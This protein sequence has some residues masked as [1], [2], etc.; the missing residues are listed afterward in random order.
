MSIS[1]LTIYTTAAAT[2]PDVECT[3]TVFP[4][5]YPR[6]A[7]MMEPGDNVYLGRYLVSG[8][9]SA[10]LYLEVRADWA[11]RTGCACG[12][13]ASARAPAWRENPATIRLSAHPSSHSTPLTKPTMNTK[14]QQQ[15]T[16]INIQPQQRQNETTGPGGRRRHRRR[17]PREER[18][19]A[20]RPADALPRR[21]LERRAAQHA[22]RPAAAVGLRQGVPRGAGAG[23]DCGARALY[24][25]LDWTGLDLDWNAA[26]RVQISCRQS[27]QPGIAPL[28][29]T[30]PSSLHSL[31]T[32]CQPDCRK[33]DR[34]TR[35]T[36]SRSRT[37]ARWTTS[38]RR[39]TSSTASGSRRPR[40]SPSSSRARC[41]ADGAGQRG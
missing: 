41:V 35:S 11:V 40:S 5:T 16:I 18:R 20:R 37:R 15:P 38:S 26:P 6:F 2:Y 13:R 12:L 29:S 36:S 4:I 8:A 14:C 22:E 28:P 24:F 33:P 31:H 30:S 39:A 10:S 1:I 27:L 32:I 25:G 7:E 19:A 34:S 3:P 21:A 23:A 17:V 9:D